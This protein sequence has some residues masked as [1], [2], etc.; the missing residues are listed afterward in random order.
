ME[1]TVINSRLDG[2]VDIISKVN[3]KIKEGWTP[4]GGIA[5]TDHTFSQAMIKYP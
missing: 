4:L 5:S 3:L 1:Y 2:I